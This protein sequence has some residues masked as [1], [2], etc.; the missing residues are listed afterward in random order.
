MITPLNAHLW[1]VA[2]GLDTTTT[3]IQALCLLG[4][5]Y[6]LLENCRYC[7]PLRLGRLYLANICYTP[8]HFALARLA[9][10]LY[11]LYI[12]LTLPAHFIGNTILLQPVLHH[13]TDLS[14]DVYSKCWHKHTLIL[15]GWLRLSRKVCTGI[16]VK[17]WPLWDT[18]ITEIYQ[19]IC[20]CTWTWNKGLIFYWP[21]FF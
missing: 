21:W 17:F 19:C 1:V 2:L 11:S 16:N 6:A 12:L 18:L 8:A 10:L 7:K 20:P 13:Q 15:Y 3:L 9:T 14:Q 4:R 5:L